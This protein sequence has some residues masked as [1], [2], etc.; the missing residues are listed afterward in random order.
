[1]ESFFD[2]L[3]KK[4]VYNGLQSRSE[5]Y[6]ILG[7]ESF[8]RGIKFKDRLCGLEEGK[9][10]GIQRVKCVLFIVQLGIVQGA[11]SWFRIESKGFVGKVGFGFGGGGRQILVSVQ[12]FLG[13]AVFYK[14]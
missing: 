2:D 9:E 10:G 12:L 5:S 14:Y 6:F 1:M 13:C 4:L 3:I 8:D 11:Q 7:F